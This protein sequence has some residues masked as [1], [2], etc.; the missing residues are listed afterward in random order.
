MQMHMCHP[1]SWLLEDPLELDAEA[2]PWRLSGWRG[3]STVCPP[4]GWELIQAG[5]GNTG[6]LVLSWWD[7]HHYI[8]LWLFPVKFY[9][10]KSPIM[11]G[12][13]SYWKSRQKRLENTGVDRR[14]CLCWKIPGAHKRRFDLMGD[15]LDTTWH[16]VELQQSMKT[17]QPTFCWVWTLECTLQTPNVACYKICHLH[18]H[19][20]CDRP[21]FEREFHGFS[22]QTRWHGR[23]P[24]L[25][26]RCR[27]A[28][29]AL[30]GHPGGL[31]GR[32][33]DFSKKDRDKEWYLLILLP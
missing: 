24:C 5:T 28:A 2:V 9:T 1:S 10:S 31:F 27:A 7:F 12:F 4:F 13:T 14:H 29:A 3:M 26:P 22:R 8:S 23:V 32:W 16:R 11:M 20:P 15:L 30:P 25:P 17:V 6:N 18:H 19:F 21:P 33:L